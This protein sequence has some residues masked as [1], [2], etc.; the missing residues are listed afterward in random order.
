MASKLGI[1]GAS[2]GTELINKPWNRRRR[3]NPHLKEKHESNL[4]K[5]PETAQSRN[6][7]VAME[8]VVRA[9]WKTVRLLRLDERVIARI[10]EFGRMPM[11]FLSAV[12][13]P[14][15]PL[16][17]PNHPQNHDEPIAPNRLAEPFPAD[18]TPFRFGWPETPSA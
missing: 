12:R 1:A 9:K 18:R 5:F 4:T 13:P 2:C 7:Q 17:R 8:G 3:E 14:E 6:R 11:L 16:P 10:A 15:A